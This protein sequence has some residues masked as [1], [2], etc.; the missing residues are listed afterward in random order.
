MSN[1]ETSMMDT[2]TQDGQLEYPIVPTEAQV[3]LAEQRRKLAIARYQLNIRRGTGWF[4]PAD[5]SKENP[6]P[7]RPRG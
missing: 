7:N 5:K 4:K 2:S 6:T 3:R 1:G